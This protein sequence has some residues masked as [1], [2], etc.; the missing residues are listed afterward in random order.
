MKLI[1]LLLFL[2]LIKFL[3]AQLV[4]TNGATASTLVNSLLGTGITVS[5]ITFQG[6]FNSGGVYQAGSFTAS[7]SVATNLGI[8]SGIVLCTGKTSDI[9]LTPTTTAPGAS[10]FS[11]SGLTSTCSNGEIRQGGTCPVYINDL[12]IL[13]GTVNYYNAA[14]LEFDFVA[15]NTNISFRYVFGSEEYDQTGSS[16]INYNCSSYNDK[17]G[18]ILSGPGISG[19]QGYT[20]NGKNIARLSNG[21]EVSINS[22]NNGVVG[23]YG[24]SPSAAKCTAANSSW[25]NGSSTTEFNGPIYGIQFNG[26]TKVLTAS[27]SGLTAGSTYHIKLIITDAND[28]AYDSGVF[29]EAGS[30][31]SPVVLPITLIDFKGSCDDKGIMLNWQTASEKDNQR[32]IIERSV[33]GVNFDKIGEIPGSVSTNNIQHYLFYDF[34]SSIGV[35]YYRLKQQDFD[36]KTTVFKIISVESNCLKEQD[37]K[38]SLYPNPGNQNLFIDFNLDDYSDISFDITNAIG[39]VV[40]TIPNKHYEKG[41]QNLNIDI[42]N[43]NPG[44]YYFKIAVSQKITV[45][46]FIKI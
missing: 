1:Y 44:I 17:F 10:N 45:L 22:V 8:T 27:Q 34:N 14:I 24:G 40:K 11:S 26:N 33:D 20:N 3:P 30:F 25:L 29:I 2:L 39:Q 38:F 28:G 43:L 9:V 19:G 31:N 5:N 18:F 36:E 21:S 23:S 35:N 4:V 41:F 32:F 46:K 15:A 42:Y 16:A 6:V 13:A 7:G 12:D 37:L